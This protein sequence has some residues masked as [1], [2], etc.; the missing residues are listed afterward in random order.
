MFWGLAGTLL[1][2]IIFFHRKLHAFVYAM[3]GRHYVHILRD[4]IIPKLDRSGKKRLVDNFH[5]KVLTPDNA[6]T[7]ITL[8][9]D[10]PLTDLEQ[11]IPYES[12]RYLVMNAP[13][14]VVIYE[15]ACRHSRKNPCQPTQVCMVIGK[16]HTDFILKIHPKTSRRI[17]TE[18]ALDILNLTHANGNVHTAWF[19]DTMKGRFYALCNCCTCCCFGLDVMSRLDTPIVAPSGYVAE[20]DHNDCIGC[21]VC[22]SKCPQKAMT[23][24]LDPSRGIPLDVRALVNSQQ[25]KH[26]ATTAA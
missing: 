25:L 3:W 14:D 17:S 12:A 6:E 1:F 16:P 9:K 24:K 13:T 23:M 19:K 26:T 4:H 8:N 5:C 10:I 7:I 21:G 18:E 20:T 15:C 2:F 22:T 11:V